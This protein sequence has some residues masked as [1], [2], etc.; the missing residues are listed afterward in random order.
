MD[1]ICS[2]CFAFINPERWNLGYRLCLSCGELH[3]KGL[4]LPKPIKIP[5]SK[6]EIKEANE[7]RRI[8]A[9]AKVRAKEKFNKE[10]EAYSKKIRDAEM[11][12]LK[13][14]YREK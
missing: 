2:N 14:K 10:V 11:A 5:P 13:K 6:E 7:L 12:R 3:A 9:E 1:Y 8:E 4:P